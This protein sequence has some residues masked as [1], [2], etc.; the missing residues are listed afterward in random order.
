MAL[1]APNVTDFVTAY[2]G[3]LAAGGVVVPCRPCW[4]RE[5]DYVLGHSGAEL[6]LH[7]DALTALAQSPRRPRLACPP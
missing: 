4:T 3:I 7:H 2:Y 6:L 5:I 1:L